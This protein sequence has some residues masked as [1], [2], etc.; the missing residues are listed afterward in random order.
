MLPPRYIVVWHILMV[1][2]VPIF[3]CDAVLMEMR[4]Q[5]CLPRARDLR[6]AGAAAAIVWELDESFPVR[7][8]R[9]GRGPCAR[10]RT[11]SAAR[12]LTTPRCSCLDG[13]LLRRLVEQ[14]TAAPFKRRAPA[15]AASGSWSSRDLAADRRPSHAPELAGFEAVTGRHPLEGKRAALHQATARRARPTCRLHDGALL[16]HFTPYVGQA[17]RRPGHE[18]GAPAGSTRHG[19]AARSRGLRRAA[20]SAYCAGSRRRH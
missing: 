11:K 18:A 20:P 12:R 17:D 19:P 3:W 2:A 7:I 4:L 14:Y 1:I 6:A 13:R 10:G 9:R 16:A 5:T 15:A 8:S